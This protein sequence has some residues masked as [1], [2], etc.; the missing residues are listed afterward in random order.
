MSRFYAFISRPIDNSA[1]VLFRVF[2]GF[3]VACEAFG[4]ILTGWVKDVFITPQF[5]FT[6]IGFEFLQPLPGV[7]MYV[8]F[9]FMGIC[10][11]FIMLG[12]RYRLAAFSFAL[13]WTG[14][15]LMQKS[16]YN[17]HYYLLM[18]LA[19]IMAFLPA[20]K[21]LSIDALRRP[22]LKMQIMPNGI[23]WF[24]IAQLFIVYTY[25][26][27]AKMSEGWVNLSF[28]E[29]LMATKKNMPLV[30]D[31]L[32]ERWVHVVVA[33]YGLV[34]DLLVI[35][36]LLWHKTRKLFFM[37][38]LFFHLFNSAVLQIGI[39]PYLSLAFCLF[40]F[41]TEVLRKV[42]KLPKSQSRISDGSFYVTTSFRLG[43]FLGLGYLTVQMLLPIRHHFIKGDVLWTEE[44]HRLSWRMMLRTRSGYA[45]IKVVD[46]ATG[47]DVFINLKDYVSPKQERQVYSY[48][49]FAW[50]FAQKLKRDYESKGKE[51]S[52]YFDGKVSVSGGTYRP[53]IDP[54]IDLASAPWYHFKHN[55]WI[56]LYEDQKE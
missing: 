50:Q 40:F 46:K 9:F 3:L 30:G 12:Y 41:P 20:H 43:T 1:L 24:I 11:L 16:S 49:D 6:F 5:T 7:G 22:N 53:L 51:V 14:V 44:G 4:A 10:G 42:F 23:R 19:Y 27:I 47:Q 26:S 8:Y 2:Y 52:V 38:S 54:T 18:L 15:Y 25:A 35:P 13:L 56:I 31:L 21:Y 33:A 28:I 34:F 55:P 32:Q 29:V 48:P 17:N 37:L 39:F 36:A 45:R